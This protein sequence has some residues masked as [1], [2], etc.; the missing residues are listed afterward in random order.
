MIAK[1]LGIAAFAL[2]LLAAGP[3]PIVKLDAAAAKAKLTAAQKQAVAP[4]IAK[5]NTQLTKA[6]A[7][8][9]AQKHKAQQNHGADHQRPHPHDGDMRAIHEQFLKLHE[10]LK[11]T[12]TPEQL[13]AVIEYVHEQMKASGLEP[14]HFA[15]GVRGH[16]V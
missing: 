7:L 12:L 6:V 11:A 8:H 9:A 13:Q 5:L 1:W 16:G 14:S 3:E 2:P 15:H 4:V 10:E